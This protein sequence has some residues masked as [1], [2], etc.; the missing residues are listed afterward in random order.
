MLINKFTFNF[1]LLQVYFLIK[2]QN[3]GYL[4]RNLNLNKTYE[5]I[6]NNTKVN[7]V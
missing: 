1:F 2:H 7:F 5:K 6:K 3:L 4:N